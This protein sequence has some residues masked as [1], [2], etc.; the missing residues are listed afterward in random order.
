MDTPHGIHFAQ[1]PNL[2]LP[3]FRIPAL[4]PKKP[5]GRPGKTVM[6][7]ESS[8]DIDASKSTSKKKYPDTLGANVEVSNPVMVEYQE[9]LKRQHEESYPLV[10][11]EDRPLITDALF[12]T[13]EQMEACKFVEFDR[14]GVYKGRQ[15]GFKGIACK[16]CQ[17]QA[18]AGRY[19]PSSEASLSQTTTS[20]TFINHMRRCRYVPKDIRDRL[21]AMPSAL[22][23]PDNT[24]TKKAMPSAL[25]SPDNTDTKKGSKKSDKPLHGGRKVFFHRLWCRVQE[26]E[27]AVT[28][29]V[30]IAWEIKKASKVSSKLG[31]EN[32]DDQGDY[33][34][35][36]KKNLKHALN[37]NIGSKRYRRVLNMASRK[38]KE[39]DRP[40]P[41]KPRKRMMRVSQYSEPDSSYCSDSD[42]EENESW[43]SGSTPLGNVNDDEMNEVSLAEDEDS[44]GHG[45]ESDDEMSADMTKMVETAARW[46]TELDQGGATAS[47]S[48]P[49]KGR[50]RGRRPPNIDEESNYTY[51]V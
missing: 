11:E 30:E 23:S 9:E 46:L 32:D 17:G 4:E 41:R 16:H 29:E 48:R 3:T 40:N 44:T 7:N 19:F 34:P 45:D 28:D 43:N 2:P 27:I 36:S 51:Y 42:D 12:I 39:R 15:L 50:G 8:I 13:L 38:R 21:E 37:K 49:P 22:E 26:L 24:D 31:D 18:G 35:S 6:E 25:E 10:T 14:V 33:E 1:D 47:I 5:R 20:M